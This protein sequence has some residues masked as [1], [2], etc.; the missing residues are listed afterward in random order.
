MLKPTLASGA[1]AL[2]LVIAADGAPA[3]HSFSDRLRIAQSQP[4]D[5]PEPYIERNPAQ[6]PRPATP[7]PPPAPQPANPLVDQ[8]A[9]QKG[10]VSIRIVPSPKSEEEMV[11]ERQEREQRAALENKLMWF[12]A[13]LVGIGLFQFIA[14]AGLGLLL[15]FALGA[16]R[17]PV[18]LVENNMS[19]VQR[20]FVGVATI[21]WSVVGD[22][23]RITP[24]LEN[25]GATPSRS[26]RVSTN[27]RASHG[28][29]PPDFSYSYSQPPDRIFLGAHGRAPI[30]AVSIPVR[31]A[32]AAIE[33]RLQL[34]LW[35][36]ATYNDMFDGSEPHFIEFCYRLD[37]SGA[38]PDRLA[39]A[40]APYGQH[41]RS[42]QDSVRPA[43][44]EQR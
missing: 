16:I 11:A 21:D 32:Q 8:N 38:P 40:F 24:V 25:G 31:D 15:W 37:I 27:W 7:T 12:A 3:R 30:G 34:Y 18:E 22:N 33:G 14:I 28:D 5:Q 26:L 44:V 17:R 23:L 4:A 13:L 36:R 2:L 39:V 43:A 9:G 19:V 35:G 6:L 42:D 10:P 20:A 29:L 41:N 1:L